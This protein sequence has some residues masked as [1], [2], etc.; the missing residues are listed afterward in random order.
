M[1]KYVLLICSIVILAGCNANKKPEPKEPI[2]Q[3]VAVEKKVVSIK[4]KLTGTYYRM[5]TK[6][7]EVFLF[8]EKLSANQ[9]LDDTKLKNPFYI[10]GNLIRIEKIYM[11]IMG[12]KY[13]K[14]F[15][16]SLLVSMDDLTL[17]KKNN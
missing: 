2:V 7:I 12:D 8:N 4:K 14:I 3:E 10:K 11:S 5:L 6:R 1:K 13:G 16:K 9:K 15:G 17:Y